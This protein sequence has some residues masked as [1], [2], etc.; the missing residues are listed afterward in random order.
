ML[1]RIIWAIFLSMVGFFL[2]SCSGSNSDSSKAITSFSFKNPAATG[3]INESAK[4]IS[5]R[6]PYGT[7]VTALVAT[8]ETTGTSVKIG[9]IVQNSGTTPN[10]FTNPVQYMV[11]AADGSAALYTVTVTIAA[12]S[13]K[14]L[15]DY[16][17][18]SPAATGIID[19]SAKT[20]SVTVPYGTDVT[21][22]VATFQTTGTSVKIGSIVQISGTT[23]NDFTNPVQYTVTDADSS[24]VT[25]TVT[26][27]IASNSAPVISGMTITSQPVMD[28]AN[29]VGSAF[30]PDGD[31]LTYSWSV[32]GVTAISTGSTATWVSP[33]IPGYY[34]VILSVSDGITTASTNT[35]VAIGSTSPWPRFKRDI[36]GRSLSATVSASTGTLKWSYL[37][38]YRVLGSPSIGAD[39]TVYFGS[40]DRNIYAI[41]SDGTLKWTYATSGYVQSTPAVDR[42][43]N[44][45]VG[46]N[47]GI[48][49]AIKSNGVLKWRIITSSMYGSSPAFGAD[50]TIYV[51]SGDGKL[52][53]VTMDGILKWSYATGG[54][55]VS[56]PAIGTDGTIYVGSTD[57]KL[58]AIHTDG[59]LMWSI[60]AGTYITSSPAIGTD[61]T[62]YVGS[63][64]YKLYA[65]NA[66]GTIKWSFPTGNA[67]FSSP[68]IGADGVIYVGSV[69][70]YL[71]AVM[72]NGTSN[73]CYRTGGIVESSPAISADGTIYV[74][75]FD[76]KI[77]AINSDGTAKWTYTTGG[78]ISLSSPAIDA[79]GT[80]YIGSEDDY[81]YAIR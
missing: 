39:G 65:I 74:G 13:A 9:S 35:S 77:H 78:S 2:I 6:V 48:L 15:T 57:G 3:T 17:F 30:D 34:S 22:M 43:G 55:I 11:A 56:S 58:Y 24:T 20:I 80:I 46:S 33:G 49:Y 25:Y 64:D 68:A 51:G 27:H 8:F 71:Y 14:A 23:P 67:V 44:V 62:I 7:N 73:W 18:A 61:G 41:N 28:L 50:G 54:L 21:A 75:S 59:T 4:T 81:L 29:L 12:S 79:A 32:G 16:S 36:Q 52:Y 40:D 53:A 70:G 37:T 38:G 26:V 66:N 10:D 63:N 42:N 1:R 5:I 76:K 31:P 72:P 19:E 60:S 47:D 45:Y 69:D